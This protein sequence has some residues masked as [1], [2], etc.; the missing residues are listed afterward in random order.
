MPS[1]QFL[2]VGERIKMLERFYKGI[3]IPQICREFRTTPRVLRNA[4]R[5]KDR[6]MQAKGHPDRRRLPP[7]TSQAVQRFDYLLWL[8]VCQW[9]NEGVLAFNAL[10]KYKCGNRHQM[11]FICIGLLDCHVS[12]FFVFSLSAYNVIPS[13]DK[14]DIYIYIYIYILVIFIKLF[15]QRRFYSVS[16]CD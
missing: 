15:F 5:M 11:R 7:L 12:L 6:L 4:R 8:Y 3:T 14:L 13:S 9:W 1:R 10:M 16:L 2:S